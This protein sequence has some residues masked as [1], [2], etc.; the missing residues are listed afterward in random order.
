MSILVRKPNDREI[1]AMKTKPV[2]TCEVSEFEWVYDEKETCLLIEGDVDVRYGANESVS[3]A[4]GDLV[5]LPKGLSCVWQVKKPVK[6]YY[7]FG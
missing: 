4:T 2:W 5:V 6:K 1:A 3:F 7:V